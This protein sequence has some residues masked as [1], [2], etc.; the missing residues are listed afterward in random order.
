MFGRGS[1]MVK[2][3]IESVIGEKIG[4]GGVGEV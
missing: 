4:M 1:G 2:I 3:C